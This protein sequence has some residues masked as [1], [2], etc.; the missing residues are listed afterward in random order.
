MRQ[1]GQLFP[2]QSRFFQILDPSRQS[3]DPAVAVRTAKLE[4]VSFTH[5]DPIP[6]DQVA[7]LLR[8]L[9]SL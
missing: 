8:F 4:D 3:R 9:R 5:H 7:D 6:A 1:P 2:P